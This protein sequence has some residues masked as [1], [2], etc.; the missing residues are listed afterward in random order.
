MA[1]YHT[2]VLIHRTK[3]NGYWVG[4]CIMDMSGEADASQKLKFSEMVSRK[5]KAHFPS[6]AG[7]VWSSAGQSLFAILAYS[8]N[9]DTNTVDEELLEAVPMEEMAH[10]MVNIAEMTKETCAKFGIGECIV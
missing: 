10:T 1:R 9:R 4:Q 3:F 5:P 2:K 6:I 8:F 7:D